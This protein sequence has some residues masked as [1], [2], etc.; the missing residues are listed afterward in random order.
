MELSLVGCSDVDGEE[1]GEVDMD[2]SCNSSSHVKHTVIEDRESGV[3]RKGG[4][5]D[6]GKRL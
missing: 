1:V 4:E 2:S 6:K 3:E 5:V